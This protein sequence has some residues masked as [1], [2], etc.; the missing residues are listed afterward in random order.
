MEQVDDDTHDHKSPLHSPITSDNE[1]GSDNLCPSSRSAAEY[2]WK[3]PSLSSSQPTSSQHFCDIR[4]WEKDRNPQKLYWWV[5]CFHS[6]FFL[7]LSIF[8]RYFCGCRFWMRRA[9]CC[10]SQER[11]LFYRTYLKCAFP[12]S[13]RSTS[14]TQWKTH[15]EGSGW[16]SSRQITGSSFLRPR[17]SIIQERFCSSVH[18]RELVQQLIVNHPQ[19]SGQISMITCK[20]DMFFAWYYVLVTFLCRTKLI[21]ITTCVSTSSRCWWLLVS[22][23][24]RNHGYGR[25]W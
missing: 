22:P 12:F 3:C 15:Q 25:H 21:A 18:L 6:R 1:T 20:T 14:K 9:C 11:Y 16:P 17:T 24:V 2:K 7:L 4:W 23:L 8:P 5:S 10:G 19:R 13:Q